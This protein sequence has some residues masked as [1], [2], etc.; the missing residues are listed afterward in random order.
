[1]YY[2]HLKWGFHEMT[3][4][5]RHTCKCFPHTWIGLNTAAES[6]TNEEPQNLGC[7]SLV[8]TDIPKVTLL[9]F[10]EIDVNPFNSHLQSKT[11]PQKNENVAA[12]CS[13]CCHLS[14]NLAF[15]TCIS[16]QHKCHD[17]DS[18]MLF[19]PLI[20]WPTFWLWKWGQVDSIF[21]SLLKTTA[22]IGNNITRALGL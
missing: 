9:I 13:F 17:L 19:K 10:S 21:K 18:K 15:H 14:P 4:P 20:T 3:N 7:W 5:F 2:Q 16:C 1:M 6:Y 12:G 11:T 8:L 22:K